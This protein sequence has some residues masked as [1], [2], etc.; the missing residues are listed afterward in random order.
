MTDTD[1]K[2]FEYFVFTY[3]IN[4]VALQLT[5]IRWGSLIKDPPLDPRGFPYRF[6][7]P[8][9]TQTPIWNTA[10]EAIW[11]LKEKAILWPKQTGI[12][13]VGLD[14][15]TFRWQQLQVR[16]LPLSF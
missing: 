14:A 2:G 5:A 8:R 16:P 13:A 11:P 12:D 7:A 1:F 4:Y 6:V 15:F 10:S 3:L 9:L